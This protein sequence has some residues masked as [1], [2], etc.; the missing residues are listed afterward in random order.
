MHDGPVIYA[1]TVVN[2]SGHSDPQLGIVPE[3]LTLVPM[4]QRMNTFSA[5][6]MTYNSHSV[7]LTHD[8]VVLGS[9]PGMM[10]VKC[11]SQTGA[12]M[13]EKPHC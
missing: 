13:G 8:R 6:L 7:K 9:I 5:F 12:T 1:D 2:K 11:S 3:L 4:Y 10:A